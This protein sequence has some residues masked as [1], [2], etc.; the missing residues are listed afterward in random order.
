MVFEDSVTIH[1]PAPE[2]WDRLLDVNCIAACMPGV[3]E[4]VQ[5]DE[6]T[7]D[8]VINA[9]VGPIAGKFSFRAHIVESDP[10]RAM[11]AEVEGTDSVTKSTVRTEMAMT[12][13]PVGERATELSY[14][15]EVDV[16][17][18]LAILGEMVLRATT[19]LMVGE[20]TKRL[21]QQLEG[22]KGMM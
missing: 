2:V 6:R 20:F 11:R 10:P 4:V 1:A 7:F 21:R 16:K 8:G 9:S 14:R 22:A 12:L 13:D 5:I 17:G 18:R 3:E 19:A 15:A